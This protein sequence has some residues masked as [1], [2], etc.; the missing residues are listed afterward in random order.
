MFNTYL[1]L[2][3]GIHLRLDNFFLIISDFPAV[4]ERVL[5]LLFAVS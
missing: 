3:G 1:F 5:V 2:A 4:V